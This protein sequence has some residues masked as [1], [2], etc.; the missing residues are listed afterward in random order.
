MAR[1]AATAPLRDRR[2]A[3]RIAVLI[4]V[5]VDPACDGTYLWARATAVNADGLFVRTEAPEPPGTALRL[6]VPDDAGV[7]IELEGVVAWTNPPGPATFDPGMGVRFVGTS[8]RARRQLMA[9]IGR[10]AYLDAPPSE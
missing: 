9:L 8:V 1:R 2:A 10:I 5:E 4:D 6:R 3:P 7:T